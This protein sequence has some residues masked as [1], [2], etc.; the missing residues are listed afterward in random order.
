MFVSENLSVNEKII[1][2]DSA[3]NIK[4]K[5]RQEPKVAA[6]SLFKIYKN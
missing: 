4:M 5:T 2:S 1:A 6:D 3:K